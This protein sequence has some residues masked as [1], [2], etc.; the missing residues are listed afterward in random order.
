LGLFSILFLFVLSNIINI[1]RMPSAFINRAGEM[2][3]VIEY[4][5]LEYYET[6]K[7]PRNLES[8]G[9]A[10]W[11]GTDDEWRYFA[12]PDFDEELP[13][14]RISGPLHMKLF[15]NFRRDGNL[16][17]PGG[18][19]VRMEGD[20]IRHSIPERIPPKPE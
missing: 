7:W 1:M 6:G 8:L 2:D 18:W 15:Y 13:E 19:Q 10:D 5:Y 9:I 20:R 16:H 14:L 4:V 12:S 11:H 3:H 17:S